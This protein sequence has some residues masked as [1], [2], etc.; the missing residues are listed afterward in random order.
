VPP[1]ATARSIWTLAR[2]WQARGEIPPDEI[3]VVIRFR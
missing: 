3:G 1:E 2:E